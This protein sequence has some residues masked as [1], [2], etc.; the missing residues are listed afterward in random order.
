MK[1]MDIRRI[2]YKCR[3]EE[4]E[5]GDIRVRSRKATRTAILTGATCN[6]GDID[7]AFDIGLYLL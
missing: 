6:K 2:V 4:G 1:E 7:I 3:M 5:G